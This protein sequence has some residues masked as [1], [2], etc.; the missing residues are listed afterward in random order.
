M[1]WPNFYRNI[2]FHGVI[3]MIDYD[4]KDKLEEAVSVM[5]D[6]FTEE[7]LKYVDILVLLHRSRKDSEKKI[8]KD[9]DGFVGGKKNN[10]LDFDLLTEM[11]NDVY[12][13][14]IPQS[15]KQIYYMDIYNDSVGNENLK[16]TL[17]EFFSNL[18][19]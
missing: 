18:C 19:N 11:K 9:S 1:F 4:S 10:G 8:S 14:L 13:D 12:F 5:H 2:D 17:K 3:Y 7:E 15:N 16:I 6:L